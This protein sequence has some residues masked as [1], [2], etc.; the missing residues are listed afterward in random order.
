MGNRLLAGIDGGASKTAATLMDCSGKILARVKA[1]GSAIVGKP[2]A[3]ALVVLRQVVKCLLKTAGCSLS[4]VRHIGLGLNGVDFD[5]EQPMQRR[6]VAAA[7]GID[8]KRLILVNDGIV[9]LWGGTAAEKACILQHGSGVTTAWRREYGGEHLFDHLD[10]G[11]LFD[12]RAAA[13]MTVARMIDGRERTTRLKAR[14][15]RH[16]GITDERTYAPILFRNLVKPEKMRTIADMVFD[17]WNEGDSA[18]TRI[19]EQALDDYACAA[20]AMVR[21]VG[22][23]KTDAVFGGGVILHAPL[24]FMAALGNRMGKL[25]PQARV[26]APVLAPDVGA[27][28]MAAHQEGLDV[29]A[30]YER[31]AGTGCMTRRR[32]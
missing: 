14:M 13:R 25:C 24:A 5:D 9:A 27:A 11:R 15:L 18:S 29:Q 21:Q 2:S 10:R 28:L 20:V 19:V 32:Q 17:L 12:L 4:D 16:L 26:M 8:R 30:L 1:G 6:D 22:A 23:R 3:D 7:L 31:Q